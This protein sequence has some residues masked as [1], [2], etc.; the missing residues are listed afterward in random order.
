MRI[1]WKWILYR[2]DWLVSYH[3]KDYMA[4]PIQPQKTQQTFEIQLDSRFSNWI[5]LNIVEGMHSACH[6]ITLFAMTFLGWLPH[7][8]HFSFS[9]VFARSPRCSGLWF[10]IKTVYPSG[11]RLLIV[12]KLIKICV[13]SVL[14]TFQAMEIPV[15][16]RY[17][18]NSHGESEVMWCKV[19]CPV[20]PWRETTLLVL[21]S[22]WCWSGMSGISIDI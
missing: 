12:I 10:L 21:R 14:C 17:V 3:L 16:S 1:D 7:I 22:F 13:V 19:L 11:F 5:A 9:I 4:L 2:R 15:V 20:P 6:E 18:L 8:L